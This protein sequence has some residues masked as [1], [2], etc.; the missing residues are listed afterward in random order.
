L[1]STLKTKVS[2]CWRPSQPN[3]HVFDAR[4]K[5]YHQAI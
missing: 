1:Y 5:W 3:K 2:R 4:R